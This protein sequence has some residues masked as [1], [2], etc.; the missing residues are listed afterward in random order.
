M[1]SI[2]TSERLFAFNVP[3]R[4]IQFFFMRYVWCVK[5]TDHIGTVVHLPQV[6]ERIVS[7]VPSQTEF[8]FSLGLAD[9]VVG[10]TKFCI[11][12]E[13]W[14][15]SKTR[16]GGTKNLDIDLILSLKPDLVLANKEENSKEQIEA[17]SGRL[18]VW[19]SDIETY[20]QALD[21]MR[22]VGKLVNAEQ[23]ALEVINQ[24]EQALNDYQQPERTRRVA[25]LIW[26]NPMFTIAR[27]TY[28]SDWL[29]KLGMENVFAHRTDS[30][31]PEVT[32]SDLM[33]AEPEMLLLSSEPFPFKEEHAAHLRKL[34]PKV[35]VVLV[36]GEMCSWYG[37]RMALAPAALQ[38]LAKRPNLTVNGAK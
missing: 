37:S 23:R 20:D 5:F 33:A 35:D 4:C 1:A 9:R 34:L 25:Y 18:A 16:V 14:F 11:H 28:I 31:Y 27:N 12:P 8:L 15:R 22:E 19:T 10:I 6:P 2:S 13:S 38:Y 3:M 26:N 32:I 21:M 17:L 29:G 7:L 30:R 24:V 36:D